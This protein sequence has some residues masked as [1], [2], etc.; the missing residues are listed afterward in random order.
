MVAICQSIHPV[1]RRLIAALPMRHRTF[2]R[3]E[4]LFAHLAQ[5][6]T[7]E[8]VR[9]IS[10]DVFDTLLFRKCSP[11]A[12]QYG[13]AR[14]LA[15]LV[16]RSGR[17]AADVL[18]MRDS[19]YAEEASSNRARGL[20]GDAHL[21]AINHR[22]AQKLLPDQESRWPDLEA[23]ALK[24]KLRYEEL[25]CYANPMMPSALVDLRQ[26]G[27]RLI[28]ISDMYLGEELVSRL[29]AHCGLRQFFDAGYVSGDCGLTKQ[30]GRLY[31]EVL[32]REG[33][34]ANTVVHIG[35]SA[36]ADGRRAAEAGMA[37]YVV[38]ERHA[39]ADCATSDHALALAC[40]D[41]HAVGASRFAGFRRSDEPVGVQ[42]GREVFGPVF[43]SYTH[44]L[45]AYCEQMRVGKVYFLSREGLLLRKLYEDWRAV[46]GSR[47]PSSAY[48]CLSRL[49]TVSASM[50]GFGARELALAANANREVTTRKILQP[51][52]L[53]DEEV[54]AYAT[55]WGLPD[56][57]TAIADFDP[58]VF[59]EAHIDPG[60]RERGRAIGDA[61]R[62]ALL[63]YLS[64]MGF[65][66]TRKAVLADVGW[67]GQ[68]HESL[69]LALGDLPRPTLHSYFLGA[70]S[71][72]D[73]RRH[74]GFHIHADFAE[75][76]RYEWAGGA[77]LKCVHIIENVCRAPHGTVISYHDGEPVFQPELE[78]G[79]RAERKDDGKIALLQTGIRD[80][81]AGYARYAEMSG[82]PFMLR[83]PRSM[84]ARLV[85]MPREVELD[86]IAG[87]RNVANFGSDETLPLVAGVDAGTLR[88]FLASVRESLWREG[89]VACRFGRVAAL[90]GAAARERAWARKLPEQTEGTSSLEDA[91]GNPQSDDDQPVVSS[92]LESFLHAKSLDLAAEASASAELVA[93]RAPMTLLE[94]VGLHASHATANILLVA[95]GEDRVRADL[96][97]IHLWL[98]HAISARMSRTHPMAMMRQ[99]LRRAKFRISNPGSRSVAARNGGAS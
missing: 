96:L 6:G 68:I 71:K 79:R 31:R 47:L 65:F 20:D 28:Y 48:L 27:F 74:K 17:E 67:G 50:R 62:R 36:E 24:E 98:R 81:V 86:L 9:T 16:G 90:L 69:E 38:T 82:M 75:A 88:S 53:S 21:T 2:R 11:E 15:E 89:A 19:C 66:Q 63:K 5:P 83:Y 18:R 23:F 70:D 30:T 84:L 99:V 13:V 14:A 49:T 73:V 44:G 25:A 64:G 76:T 34:A 4:D 8:G 46:F 58:Q 22:W 91:D 40:P 80:F 77:A 54:S 41:W 94:L 56:P 92:P 61:A 78:P 60:L 7:L 55:A 52:R 72:G 51:L 10:F 59:A 93:W 45:A 97:P 42:V 37:A 26:R 43:A 39:A 29:L 95:F 85:F 33:T 35:D 12:V 3:F 1:Q 32:K 57:D 87:I